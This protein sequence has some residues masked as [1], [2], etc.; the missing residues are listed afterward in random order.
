MGP[1]ADHIVGTC[2]YRNLKGLTLKRRTFYGREKDNAIY[3]IALAN[4]VLHNSPA[5]HFANRDQPEAWNRAA[6]S[7]LAGVDARR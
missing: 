5:S 7:F 6:T 2:E 3:P 1:A 4:L